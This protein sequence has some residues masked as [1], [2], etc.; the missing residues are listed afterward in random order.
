MTFEKLSSLK[1]L[2]KVFRY[3]SLTMNKNWL[4]SFS[5]K[6]KRSKLT[7][8]EFFSSSL[9]LWFTH[10]IT[11]L[12]AQTHLNWMQL[13]QRGER[14]RGWQNR[15]RFGGKT[16]TL[17]AGQGGWLI[18]ICVLMLSVL[19]LLFCAGCWWRLFLQ[20]VRYDWTLDNVDIPHFGELAYTECVICSC[21][22]RKLNSIIILM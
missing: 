10:I 6:K 4:L 15:W 17:P 3:F 1:M 16:S 20:H 19:L 7:G 22:N 8:D 5:K 18:R 9:Y 13:K 2:Q 12:A 21:L 14:E 11:S